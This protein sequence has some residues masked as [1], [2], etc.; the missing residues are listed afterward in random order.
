MA[1]RVNLLLSCLFLLVLPSPGSYVMAL[2][3]VNKGK[4][5]ED[6]GAAS[7]TRG[8]LQYPNVGRPSRLSPVSRLSF[9]T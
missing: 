3:A 5:M 7:T 8:F 1:L 4:Y 2:E 9:A 6:I